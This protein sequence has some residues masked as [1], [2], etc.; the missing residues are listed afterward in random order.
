M[1]HLPLFLE[2]HWQQFFMLILVMIAIIIMEIRAQRESAKTLSA[3]EAVS[4]LNQGKAMIID[5]REPVAYQKGHI[6]HAI[7][8]SPSDFE[9]K[10][11][12]KY[13]AKQLILVCDQGN[14]S[15]KLATHLAKMGYT[16]PMAL[17]GGINAWLAAGFPV[18]KGD[19]AK[20]EM[21]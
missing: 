19:S 5:I 15:K 17:C 13:Q 8:A 6:L 11:M 20:G 16:N 7:Q 2:R 18:V 12:K 1:E 21:V 10:E 9:K 14:A 4:M 3:Q